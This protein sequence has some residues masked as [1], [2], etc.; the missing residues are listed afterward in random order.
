MKY[1]I[2]TFF[3]LYFLFVVPCYA[4]KCEYY[5]GTES[6]NDG[7]I[8]IETWDNQYNPFN[9]PFSISNSSKVYSFA[10]NFDDFNFFFVNN[11]V[12]PS[13]VDLGIDYDTN[14][15][16]ILLLEGSPESI[17]APF[18]N[19]SSEEC[20]VSCGTSIHCSYYFEG[21][22][23]VLTVDSK[24]TGLFPSNNFSGT[25]SIDHGDYEQYFTCDSGY[26]CPNYLVFDYF[27][28]QF[29]LI[30]LRNLRPGAEG[31]CLGQSCYEGLLQGDSKI[32]NDTILNV[33]VRYGKLSANLK[34]NT[35]ATGSSIIDPSAPLS[36]E[37]AGGFSFCE[38]KKVLVIFNVLHT[39][40]KIVKIVIPLALIIVSSIELFKCFMKND[41]DAISKA[42]K[43][44]AMKAII[45][46]LIFFIPT[47]ANSFI[48]YADKMDDE[49]NSCE[50]CFTGKPA[51]E[52]DN[53]IDS[54]EE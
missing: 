30:N 17:N 34:L 37:D 39:L 41:N 14:L 19:D 36:S 8:A 27:I 3:L 54:A 31:Q 53:L 11:D 51:G 42:G 6:D 28:D 43:K 10:P 5:I 9:S 23:G 18:V 33:P 40:I 44:L 48:S 45:G 4:L 13:H 26:K 21:L 16:H 50:V 22:N 52:C 38:Q 15:I 12:C 49:M 47:I 46:I 29:N 1:K 24:L 35:N 7:I 2:I 32:C 25:G 20:D